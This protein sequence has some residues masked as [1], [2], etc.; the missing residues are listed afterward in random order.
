MNRLNYVTIALMLTALISSYA[1]AQKASVRKTATVENAALAQEENVVDDYAYWREWFRLHEQDADLGPLPQWTPP[2]METSGEQEIMLHDPL[3]G[4]TQVGTLSELFPQLFDENGMFAP[5][6]ESREDDRRSLDEFTVGEIIDDPS[7]WPWKAHC[8][9]IMSSSIGTTHG[10][11]IL[12]DGQYVLTAGHV[13]YNTDIDEWVNMIEVIPGYDEGYRPYGTAFSSGYLAWTG[14]TVAHD[15]N[16]DM[17]VIKL[18]RPVGAIT[19]WYPYS[20][21]TDNNWYFTNTF[22]SVGYPCP[23]PFNGIRM[24]YRY[25]P[26]DSAN[27]NILYELDTTAYGCMSGGGVYYRN[28]TIPATRT[29]HAVAS[30]GYGGYGGFN[31]ITATKSAGIGSYVFNNGWPEWELAALG[32]TVSPETLMTGDS[33]DDL[34]FYVYNGSWLADFNGNLTVRLYLSTN[35]II[36]TSDVLLSTVTFNNVH[37][38]SGRSV[39]LT[40]PSHPLIPWNQTGTRWLGVMLMYSDTI[41]A[42][43]VTSY[44]DAARVYIALAPPGQATD[45]SPNNGQVSIDTQA[46]LTW[47]AGGGATSHN[48]YWGES[49]PPPFKANQTGTSYDPSWMW[50]GHVYY[51]RIDEVNSAGTTIGQVWHYTT[52][53][54]PEPE[55]AVEP[56]PGNGAENV[57]IDVVCSW[58]AGNYTEVFDVYFG[59]TNPPP[60][61]Q[62]QYTQTYDPPGNLANNTLYYWKI[63]SRNPTGSIGSSLWHFTTVVHAPEVAS[64][65]IPAD[66]A[67]NVSIH[68]NLLWTQGAWTEFEDLFFGSTNPPPYI[69]RADY[70]GIYN[71]PG[72]LAELTTYYWRV[73]EG[74]AGGL[75]MG[76]LWSFTTEDY[77]EPPGMPSNPSPANN[78]TGISPHTSY[79]FTPGTNATYHELWFFEYD[80]YYLYW[81]GTDTIVSNLVFGPLSPNTYYSWRIKEF[82]GPVSTM[83][84]PWYF[85]TGGP[86][87]TGPPIDMTIRIAMGTAQLRWE[88]AQNG[89]YYIVQRSTSP[90]FSTVYS[91]PARTDTFLIDM[92]VGTSPD[93]VRYYRVIAGQ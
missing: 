69:G 86:E 85:T 79:S 26:F 23:S 60:F 24:N 81:G 9:L 4:E 58:A 54:P 53:F 66:G 2:Q 11:G 16:W 59:T 19:G 87:P 30:H 67:T 56:D 84:P 48:V 63:V 55:P 43:N 42:N 76:P 18:N 91:F 8:K 74:N 15:W 64:N 14:W 25:G 28:F 7:V 92:T 77:T 31:R 82:N 41:A 6:F 51:W 3:T 17:A 93:L 89:Y 68:A 34:S 32:C 47:V 12:I 52:V 50:P 13:V 90:D 5:N 73:Q 62:S 36:S 27:A 20:Y 22:H 45:P 39:E 33:F 29:V 83:G 70:N 40:W 61:I 35:N 37:V 65:P 38:D 49:N 80:D 1:V 10:S 46:L 78:A 57:P 72:D 75:V 88:P 44:D 21:N 71:T